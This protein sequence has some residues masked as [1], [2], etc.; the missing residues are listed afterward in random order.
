MESLALQVNEF[1]SLLGQI[2]SEP[3]NSKRD[4]MESELMIKLNSSEIMQILKIILTE[5]TPENLR[6][7]N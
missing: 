3:D 2:S 1:R 4:Q 6:S 5:H 7:L